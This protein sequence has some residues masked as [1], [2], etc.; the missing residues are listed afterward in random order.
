MRTFEQNLYMGRRRGHQR[1]VS[2]FIDA[3]KIYIGIPL[4]Y[5]QEMKKFHINL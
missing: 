1:V 3:E 4:P 2:L 5:A